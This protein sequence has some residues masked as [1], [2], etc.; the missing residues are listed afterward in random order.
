[1]FVQSW[2]NATMSKELVNWHEPM[3]IFSLFRKAISRLPEREGYD[4]AFRMRRAIQYDTMRRILPKEQWTK[5]E[6]VSKQREC[7]IGT[8]LI[9]T[10]YR[11]RDTLPRLL[12]R[13]SKRT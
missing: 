6:E 2:K 3:K 13:P 1:M 11:I 9:Q 5:P 4:R 12:R 10:A 7:S 8:K